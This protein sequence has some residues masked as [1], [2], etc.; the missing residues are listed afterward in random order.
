GLPEAARRAIEAG[1]VQN[2]EFSYELAWKFIRRW[3]AHN[4]GPSEVE[5]VS[6][7]HLFRL[8]A[9]HGLIDNVE[10]WMGYHQARNLTSH[11]YNQTVAR[12]IALLADAFARDAHRLLDALEARND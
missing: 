6:R 7:R 1:V 3:L 11:A 9:E 8:A 5:G 2:F 4:L 10:T 12:E